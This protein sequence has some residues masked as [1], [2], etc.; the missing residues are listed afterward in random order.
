MYDLRYVG[1]YYCLITVLRSTV[2]PEYYIFFH[3][4]VDDTLSILLQIE[5]WDHSMIMFPCGI[6]S[7]YLDTRVAN[8]FWR[9]CYALYVFLSIIGYVYIL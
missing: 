3:L 9:L 4:T 8:Y 6:T 7:S 1:S 5:N 2:W